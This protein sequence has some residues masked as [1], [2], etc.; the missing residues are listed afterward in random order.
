[1]SEINY[2]EEIPEGDF[3][4]NLKLIQKYQRLELS[5]IAK[6]KYGMY[7]KDSFCGGIN[8]DINLITCKDKI[9]ILSKLQS[10]VLHWYYTYLLHPGMNRTDAT[11]HQHLYWPV[12]R[13]S[14]Q[15][16]VN[17]CDTCQHTKLSNK[18]M[19]NYQL[20]KLSKYHGTKFF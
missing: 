12:I 11:I 2:I 4:I 17:S 8:S 9:V 3:P 10:Y 14:A 16:E 1:M 19:V 18:T 13:K 7:H 5:I 6:Y 20:R 15:K